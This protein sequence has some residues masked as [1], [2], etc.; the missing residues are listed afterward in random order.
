MEDEYEVNSSGQPELSLLAVVKVCSIFC[1][2]LRCYH[3]LLQLLLVDK[4]KYSRMKEKVMTAS[5]EE[6]TLE[7]LSSQEKDLVHQ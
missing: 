6:L 1:L 2:I 7:G 5:E 4:D 3:D